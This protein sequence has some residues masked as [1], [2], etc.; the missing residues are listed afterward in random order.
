MEISELSNAEEAVR[1]MAASDVH[2]YWA[3][4]DM[5]RYRVMLTRTVAYGPYAALDPANDVTLL[6]VMLPDD[7]RALVFSQPHHDGDLWTP[8]RF[9]RQFGPQYAGW[10]S[11]VRPLLAALAWAAPECSSHDYDPNDANVVGQLLAA[12]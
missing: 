7:P 12:G 1:V 2:I 11:G 4:G 6:I 3:P 5:T 10:W 8:G 9:L